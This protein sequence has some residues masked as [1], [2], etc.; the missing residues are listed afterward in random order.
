M[1]KYIVTLVLMIAAGC[2]HR[3]FSTPQPEINVVAIDPPTATAPSPTSTPAPT[4]LGYSFEGVYTET[5]ASAGVLRTYTHYPL[6]HILYDEILVDDKLDSVE[7]ICSDQSYDISNSFK[8]QS[9][10][11]QIPAVYS[12]WQINMRPFCYIA[13]SVE[14][15]TGETMGI[16]FKSHCIPCNY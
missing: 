6:D 1:K 4:S 2:G 9:A 11:G 16:Q 10:A 3:E 14:N 12:S 13:F 15:V 8:L 5:V 7:Y